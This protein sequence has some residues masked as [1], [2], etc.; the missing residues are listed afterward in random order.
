MRLSVSVYV[1]VNM[2]VK[3]DAA[4]TRLNVTRF[5]MKMGLNIGYSRDHLTI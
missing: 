3:I 4:L 5:V 1:R 2:Y